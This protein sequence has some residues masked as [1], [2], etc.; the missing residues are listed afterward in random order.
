MKILSLRK[1]D[2]INFPIILTALVILGFACVIFLYAF[3]PSQKIASNPMRDTLAGTSS[4][5]HDIQGFRYTGA[6]EGRKVISVRAD[7]FLI[8]KKKI[9][10]LRF[11]LLNE[12]R[13]DN[14]RID[15]Y[16][17]QKKTPP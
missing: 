11:G 9:G 3:Q 12:V 6:F 8:R 4:Q 14:A 1:S 5:N 2:P 17:R 10:F 13:F 16:G 15:I 7:R